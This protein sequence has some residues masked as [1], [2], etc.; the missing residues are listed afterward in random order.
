MSKQGVHNLKSKAEFEEAM[1]T[2]DTLMVLDCFATWCGPC[3]VIAPT[4]VKFSDKYPDARFYKIDVNEVPDVAQ[5]LQIRAMPTFLLFKNGQK[6]A[7]VVGA[8]PSA[9]EGAIKSNM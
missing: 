2:P 9:L 5:E 1:Q 7:E 3:K 4:V 6:I 8:N